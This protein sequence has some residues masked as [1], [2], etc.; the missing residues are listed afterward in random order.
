MTCRDRIRPQEEAPGYGDNVLQ[1]RYET[2]PRIL[3]R[4]VKLPSTLRLE[5][6]AAQIMAALF[7][8]ERTSKFRTAC[9]ASLP[10]PPVL[11]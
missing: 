1:T 6:G 11:G 4:R 8:G 2:S 10:I 5:G 9:P 7:A 3:V